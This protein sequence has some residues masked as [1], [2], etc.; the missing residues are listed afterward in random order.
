M[1]KR[2]QAIQIEH[3]FSKRKNFYSIP[4]YTTLQMEGS[5]KQSYNWKN[6]FYTMAGLSREMIF[7]K[8]GAEV[9]DK[10]Y[11]QHTHVTKTINGEKQT[12]ARTTTE[13]QD[14]IHL[15]FTN[16]INECIEHKGYFRDADLLDYMV[17]LNEKAISKNATEKYFKRNLPEVLDNY[18][19]I[20]M[21]ANKEQKQRFGF[22]GKSSPSIIVKAEDIV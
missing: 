9:A 4:S 15:I 13:K 3:G 17:I 19:W 16:I 7:R 18:G 12:V 8:E 5:S 20:R 6:N 1:L 11:P 10:L 14:E 2:A 22:D 21:R